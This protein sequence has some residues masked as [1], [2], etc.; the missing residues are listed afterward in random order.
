MTVL[1]L[2]RLKERRRRG[3]G[4]DYSQRVAD[5]ALLLVEVERL[6]SIVADIEALLD[7]DADFEPA[8]RGC[9]HCATVRSIRAALA[10]PQVGTE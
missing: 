5:D 1:D 4:S 2:E 3:Y 6:R 7:P 9:R 10:S 8:P